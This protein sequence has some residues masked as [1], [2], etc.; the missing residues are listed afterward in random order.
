GNTAAPLVDWF[1]DS[2]RSAGR[3]YLGFSPRALG[4]RHFDVHYEWV[5]DRKGFTV[6]LHFERP[7]GADG[8]A[9]NQAMA[10]RL[11]EL[12]HAAGDRSLERLAGGKTRHWVGYT[13]SP[14]ADS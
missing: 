3:N 13:V 10:D 9:W 14:N 2:N 1:H 11:Q 6:G 7:A 8:R 5:F 4:L 12:V